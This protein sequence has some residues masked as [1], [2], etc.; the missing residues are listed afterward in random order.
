MLI[1]VNNKLIQNELNVANRRIN[2]IMGASAGTF[3]RIAPSAGERA[4]TKTEGHATM[5][6][7]PHAGDSSGRVCRFAEA[8]V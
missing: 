8:G 5:D 1:K 2:R 3:P 4:G 7:E 6:P